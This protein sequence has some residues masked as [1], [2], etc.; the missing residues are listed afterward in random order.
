MGG[1]GLARLCHAQIPSQ[2]FAAR[3]Y[4]DPR[5]ALRRLRKAR[6]AYRPRSAVPDAGIASAVVTNCGIVTRVKARTRHLV[7]H[8]G[9]YHRR[10]LLFPNVLRTGL[11]E[12][13]V[14]VCCRVLRC[15]SRRGSCGRSESPAPTICEDCVGSD[16]DLRSTNSA[17]E[18]NSLLSK[19]WVPRHDIRLECHL[20]A[21]RGGVLPNA[22]L[23]AD[24]HKLAPLKTGVRLLKKEVH[25]GGCLSWQ[26]NHY[27]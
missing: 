11:G 13:L 26:N 14:A 4:P 16:V 20:S 22:R 17:K 18:Q 23:A 21:S 1:N 2:S 25:S 27:T 24:A 12:A 7:P 9:K 15:G 6:L 10:L 5:R 19:V 3:Q 8:C